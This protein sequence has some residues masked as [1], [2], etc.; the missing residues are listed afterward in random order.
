MSPYVKPSD[1]RNYE[2][3]GEVLAALLLSYEWDRQ[4]LA[5]CGLSEIR[6]TWAVCRLREMILRTGLVD[7]T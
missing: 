4:E 2:N 7:P 3:P 6:I 5:R 1:D